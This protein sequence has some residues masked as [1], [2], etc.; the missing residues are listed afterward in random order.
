MWASGTRQAQEVQQ[1][2]APLTADDWRQSPIKAGG[3]GPLTAACAFV[4]ATSQRG[5]RLGHQV[6]V[7]FRRGLEPGAEITYYV[8]NAPARGPRTTLVRMSG[9]RWPVET[10]LEEGKTA[11]GMDHYATRSWRG[12]HH[13]MTRTFLAHHFLW[14]LRLK[15]KKKHQRSHS[16]KPE[17]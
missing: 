9:R 4:R 13:Q 16:H 8:S 14:R 1:L 15:G 12:G 2:G 11:L 3:K 10:A 5:R 17:S 6:W 7:I